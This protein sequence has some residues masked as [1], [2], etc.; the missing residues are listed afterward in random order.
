[1]LAHARSGIKGVYGL[2]DYADEKREALRLWGAR[3]SSINER[4]EHQQ[5]CAP[6]HVFDLLPRMH[7]LGKLPPDC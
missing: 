5:S 7:V 1:V 4:E 6:D 2:H 3:L